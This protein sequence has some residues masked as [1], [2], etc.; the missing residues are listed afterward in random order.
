MKKGD[1]VR[2]RTVINH[3]AEELS[4]WKYGVVVKEYESWEKIVSILHAGT[5]VRI[6]AAHVQIHQR[7]PE[8]R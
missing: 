2:F 7:G 1:M 4:E 8:K 6:K 3:R 5:V